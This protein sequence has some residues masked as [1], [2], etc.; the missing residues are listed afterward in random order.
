MECRS[1][2]LGAAAG[3]AAFAILDRLRRRR[4]RGGTYHAGMIR[5]R[6]ELIEQY[7]QLHDKTWEEVM[8][9]M[10]ASNMRD[11]VVWFHPTTNMMFH[12]FIYV[13]TD[14]D[15]DMVRIAAD[16]VV[17]LL[18]D[19]LR[20][21][22][23]AAAL[24]RSAAVAGRRWRPSAP[25]RVVVAAPAGQSLRGLG[26]R[27]F[28]APGSEPVL[29]AKPPG[30]QDVHQGLAA[31]CAQPDGPGSRV[32]ELQTAA[33][34]RELR[35]RCWHCRT[36]VMHGCAM[37]FEEDARVVCGSDRPRYRAGAP[38]VRMMWSAGVLRYG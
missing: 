35:P 26:G 36:I 28:P 25:G 1:L 38:V 18:V 13:G 30:R 37:A 2:L 12:Q 29:H 24:E 6:P 8:A 19:V 31:S 23:G 9:R 5:A 7:Q 11:F 17:T 27:L 21:V 20:A 10:Y 32:D 22:P 14:F 15:A 3:A 34:C 4:L 16:P 33:L